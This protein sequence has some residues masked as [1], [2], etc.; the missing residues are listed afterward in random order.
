MT[1]T[2]HTQFWN[3]IEARKD[4]SK[5]LGKVYDWLN[6]DNLGELVTDRDVFWVELTWSGATLPAYILTFIKKWAAERGYR[7]LYDAIQYA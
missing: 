5:L 1:D 4:D 3:D 6:H 7:Y 2:L